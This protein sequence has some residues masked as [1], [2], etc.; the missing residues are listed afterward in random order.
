MSAEAERR[1][2]ESN[3][4]VLSVEKCERIHRASLRILAETGVRLYAPEAVALLRGGGAQALGD[5]LVL[6]PPELVEWALRA[7][8]AEVTL[9]DR[10]GHPALHL[11]GRNVYFGTGS[12]CPFIL[13][14][15]TGERRPFTRRDVEQ[16]ITL[17][18]HL[19]NI[20]FVL[21]IGLISDVPIG[22]SDLH[23]FEAMVL[24]TTKPVVFTAH[25][26]RNCETI[27]R[28][29]DCV[30]GGADALGTRPSVAYFAEVDCPLKY[31]AE[32]CRK[33]LLMAERRLPVILGAGPM[34]GA[35]GPQTHAGALAL[36]NAECLAGIVMA[37]LKRE[38]APVI[39]G[40]G[41][42]PFDMRSAI[43]PYGAPELFLN[44]AAAADLARFYG[45]PTWGY[46]GCGDAKLLDQ[47]SAVEITASVLMSLLSGANLVH[48][49][50]YLESGLVGSFDAI[51]LADSV[52]EMGRQ[53]VKSIDVDDETLA[54]DVVH[55]VGHD[56]N[57][58]EA[59]HTLRHFREVWYPGLFDRRK[60]EDWVKDGRLT[61]GERVADEVR[62][63]LETHAP[64]VL[65]EEVR[66][67]LRRLVSR[68]EAEVK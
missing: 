61:M 26:L 10:A 34:M 7:A 60:V 24:N 62:R 9:H 5:D 16:G 64:P 13:D 22:V 23:Q 8:P 39:C 52:I 27:I 1:S 6:V 36:A 63:I 38:G 54:L 66:K 40:L 68:A 50:G 59:E 30:A 67:E 65:P 45:L 32:T 42:H 53:L 19:R 15:R 28:M 25:D 47:Q 18:D 57:Y 55:A 31:A 37:Q 51:V 41:I 4:A 33:V 21:S 49:V 46:A 17:C 58:L 3:F 20:D 14:S 35:T 11:R 56:G 2:G 48:D 43:L 44:T 29:A 12:D